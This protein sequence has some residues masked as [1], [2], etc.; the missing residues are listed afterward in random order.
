MKSLIV[1][2]IIFATLPTATYAEPNALQELI[3]KQRK[4]ENT[5]VD[6]DYQ[7]NIRAQSSTPAAKRDPW[8]NVRNPDTVQPKQK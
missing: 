6:K 4:E 5:N 3:D 8:G 1:A 7:R 2:A